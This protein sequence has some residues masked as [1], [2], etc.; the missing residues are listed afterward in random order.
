MHRGRSLDIRSRGQAAAVIA[1]VGPR[2]NEIKNTSNRMVFDR[3]PRV[4]RDSDRRNQGVPFSTI[5]GRRNGMGIIDCSRL[6]SWSID[7]QS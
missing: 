4:R 1:H 6:G 5:D 3:T 2:E 7:S